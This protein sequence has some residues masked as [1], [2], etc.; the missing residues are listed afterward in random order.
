MRKI[1]YIINPAAGH[2][3]SKETINIINGKM[4]KTNLDYSISISGHPGDIEIIARESVK[5]GYTDVV[6]VGGDGTVLEAFNGIFDKDINLGII[7]AGTGND[8]VRMLDVDNDFEKSVDRIIQGKTKKIDIGIVNNTHFLNVV[9]MGI[10][11]EIVKKTESAKKILKGSVAYLYSTFASLINYKCKSVII[12]IDDIEYRREVYL[13]A[14]GNGKYFGGGMMVTPGA[15]LTSEDLEVVIIN[16]MKKSKFT[17][18]FRKV[19]SGKH[20]DENLV[21][22]FKGKN[23]KISSAE[24]ILINADGNIVGNTQ[25]AI[26]ILPKAQNVII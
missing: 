2:G 6:A 22:V 26:Q 3:E 5:E 8:F 24:P 16:K 9:G 4:K 10:D 17:I 18:L 13:V 25:A 11:G 15:S 12:E 14:I 23:I 7:A 1:K 19:F 20:V 21:E